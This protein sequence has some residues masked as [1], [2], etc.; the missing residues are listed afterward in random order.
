MYAMDRISA[1]KNIVALSSLVVILVNQDII[2]L[3]LGLLN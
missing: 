1:L 2:I 3:S